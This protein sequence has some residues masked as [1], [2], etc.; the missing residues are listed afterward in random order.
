M[1]RQLDPFK[2]DPVVDRPGNRIR[3]HCFESHRE[4]NLRTKW[5][6]LAVH[7][8]KPAVAEIPNGLIPQL[9]RTFMGASKNLKC[10]F[11]AD[12]RPVLA[13][14]RVRG[15]GKSDDNSTPEQMQFGEAVRDD[16]SAYLLGATAIHYGHFLLEAFSRAWA[17]SE[18]RHQVAIIVSPPILDFARSLCAFIPGLSERMEVVQATTRF[19]H[20]TAAS[21]SFAISR[22][23]YVEFKRMCER[24]TERALPSRDAVTEQPVYLSRARLKPGS[25]RALFGELRLE[26]LFESEG[27]RIVHPETLSIA[28]QISVVNRHKWVVAP[29]GSACHTRL[30]SCNGNNLLMLTS[31]YIHPNYVLCDLLSG[32]ATHYANVFWTPDLHEQVP[33]AMKPVA[34]HDDRLLGVLKDLGLVRTSARLDTPP[35]DFDAEMERSIEDAK[36]RAQKRAKRMGKRANRSDA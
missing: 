16:R 25:R 31:D 3:L 36:R 23:A 17:W 9:S 29:M 15:I 19:H 12:N 7:S 34:L 28:E 33:P 11:D 22:E 35:A 2:N 6:Q 27:F 20:V 14:T 21:P 30:F 13:A 10:V 8:E 24:V 4:R 18:S 5:S 26:R 1:S 32:G